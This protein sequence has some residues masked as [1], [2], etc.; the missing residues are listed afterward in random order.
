MRD[1]LDTLAQRSPEIGKVV[2]LLKELSADEENILLILHSFVS[3]A[4]NRFCCN[5]SFDEMD[6]FNLGN[7]EIVEYEII[8]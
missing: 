2:G 1:E 3:R 4:V 7:C 5:L 6:N 8:T